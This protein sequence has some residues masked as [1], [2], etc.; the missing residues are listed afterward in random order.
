[1]PEG[2]ITWFVAMPLVLLLCIVIGRRLS[3]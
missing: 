1:V 3:S 2:L